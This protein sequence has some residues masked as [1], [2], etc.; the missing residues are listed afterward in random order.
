M[1]TSS[2]TPVN[3]GAAMERFAD[4]RLQAINPVIVSAFVDQA[5]RTL[6]A[7]R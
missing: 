5:A 7:G 3:P 4:D 2:R 1:K 6:R